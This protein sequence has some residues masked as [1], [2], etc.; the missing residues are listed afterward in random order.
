MG[1]NGGS[2]AMDS[3]GDLSEVDCHNSK[4]AGS[5]KVVYYHTTLLL[6][7]RVLLLFTGTE[8]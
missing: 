4:E 3:G 8:G 5:R 7:S 1:P 2:V 6:N